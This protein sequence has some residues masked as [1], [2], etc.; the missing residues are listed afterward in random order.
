VEVSG[1]VVL[2]DVLGDDL[3]VVFCGTAAGHRSAELRQYYAGPGNKFWK[4]LADAGFTPETLR[5]C[6]FQR[7]LDYGIGLTDLN[8]EQSGGDDELTRDGY[9]ATGLER[10]VLSYRPR[11]LAFTSGTAAKV[12]YECRKVAW[13]RQEKRIGETIVWVLPSTSGMARRWWPGLKHHWYELAK[14]LEGG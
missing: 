2:P 3:D 11:V 13:G 5:P 12:Y 6:E 9:D 4:V 14:S 1:M 8:K 10:K 7:V